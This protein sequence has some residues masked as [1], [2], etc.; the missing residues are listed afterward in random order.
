MQ[1]RGVP[2]ENDTAFNYS[3]CKLTTISVILTVKY[4][5]IRLSKQGII[6]KVTNNISNE[7]FYKI[8]YLFLN[9]FLM[10]TIDWI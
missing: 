5:D 4:I 8:K 9:V 10:F 2:K 3:Q 1:A 7:W 6:W